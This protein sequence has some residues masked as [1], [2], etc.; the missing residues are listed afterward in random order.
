MKQSITRSSKH[1][2]F[3]FSSKYKFKQVQYKMYPNTSN[4]IWRLAMKNTLIIKFQSLWPCYK[5][6]TKCKKKKKTRTTHKQINHTHN[7]QW[8]VTKLLAVIRTKKN[9]VSCELQSTKPRTCLLFYNP[10]LYVSA[11]KS[12]NLFWSSVQ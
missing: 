12:A 5:V 3:A 2:F 8:T 10:L 11:A 7:K 9:I 6:I 1:P 4:E